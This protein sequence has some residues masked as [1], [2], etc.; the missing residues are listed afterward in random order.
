ML[1]LFI[2]SLAEAPAMANPTPRQANAAS[3]SE[4]GEIRSKQS[5]PN[6]SE[7]L[8][9]SLLGVVVSDNS[10]L[11]WDALSTR[12][13]Q[14]GVDYRRVDWRSVQALD[15]LEGLSV[16]LL[17]NVE[18]VSAQQLQVLQAWSR[19]GGQLI[20][21]GNLGGTSSASVQAE[22]RS[23]M[24]AYWAF[25]LPTENILRLNSRR[26]TFDQ[27][28]DGAALSGGVLV[29]MGVRSRTVAS[30]QSQPGL[31][32]RQAMVAGAPAVIVTENTAFLGWNWGSDGTSAQSLEFD[33]AWLSALLTSDR[34]G[35]LDSEASDPSTT[36][37]PAAA[38]LLTRQRNRS[39]TLNAQNNGDE[40]SRN[41]SQNSEAIAQSQP[42]TSSRTSSSESSSTESS[43]D[44]LRATESRSNR[45]AQRQNSRS[46]STPSNVAAENTPSEARSLPLSPRSEDEFVDPTEQIAP[47]GLTVEAS[48]SPISILESIAMQEELEN[49]I[50]RFES[51][52]LAAIA[53]D[54]ATNFGSEVLVADAS[55]ASREDDEEI[56][57][58]STSGGV[59]A[60]SSADLYSRVV[61]HPVLAEARDILDRFPD[62]VLQRQYETAR[63]Q[64]LEAR[65]LLWEN[66]PSDRPIAQ[67]E[68]RSIWLDRGTIV[69]A[70]SR[71]ALARIFDRLAAA[72]INTVFVETVNAGYPIYP[73]RVAPQ[74]NPMTSHWDPLQAAVE[75]AH[76]RNMEAHAWVWVFAA[77]N[78]RHNAILGLPDSYPGPVL[79]AHPDWANADRQGRATPVG[80]NKPFLDPANPNVRRYSLDL[81]R[82]IVTQ[83]D[84]DGL[85]LDYIRYPFQNAGSGNSYGYGLSARYRFRQL[86]G[87]DP[88]TLSPNDRDLWAQWTEFRME[89]VNSFVGEVADEIRQIRPD[90]VLSA[91]VFAMPEHERIHKLQQHWES[92]A[93]AGDVD[94]IVTMSYALDTNRFRRLTAPWLLDDELDLGSVIMVPGI[95][96]LNLP[97]AAAFDQIQLLRDTPAGGY[98]LFA[99][100]HLSDDLSRL[101]TRTQQASAPVPF[102]DPFAAAA[103]RFETLRRECDFFINSGEM[104]IREAEREAWESQSAA[105]R[106]QLNELAE[107]PS[108]ESIQASRQAFDQFRDRFGEW[109]YLHSLGHDYRVQI[110]DYRL[111]VIDNLLTYGDDRQPIR[112]AGR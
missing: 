89:Q 42:S 61:N 35:S 66:F 15:D 10:S 47:A 106:D 69:N 112:Q 86:T 101:F 21:S 11:N 33:A 78:Q 46:R 76:E 62:L 25:A 70:G 48:P 85:H 64:W 17:P 37:I 84:V 99:A 96:L 93:Q 2:G 60:G 3:T 55:Q 40:R 74:Q 5:R 1:L 107:N 49:L 29:P 51:A 65:Q 56:R 79:A 63:Q 71:Q 77:G 27:D 45:R 44:E 14:T 22:V 58:D 54:S 8:E 50:G 88:I 12:L 97:D 4:P 67:P 7:R 90:V 30:W 26:F 109:M 31:V 110:W 32:D 73:S 39:A 18:S 23:L 94:M 72:G 28:V 24:G 16:L 102:R 13:D 104:W 75:L 98:A 91:A 80:Q 19:Q 9:S 53:L 68:V 57:R 111:E 81:Y 6:S 36:S 34:Q 83:Y 87:V 100:E 105:L 82:E 108:R 52:L 41:R 95:Q 59:G 103:A 20:A 43:S 92:W 38:T